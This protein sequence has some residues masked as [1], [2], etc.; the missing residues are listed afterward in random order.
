MR[1][2]AER[3]EP[4]LKEPVTGAIREILLHAV[5]RWHMQGWEEERNVPVEEWERLIPQLSA[6]ERDSAFE[7]D[8]GLMLY[9][10]QRPLSGSEVRW[11]RP[12]WSAYVWAYCRV[13]L[14][15]RL[16]SLPRTAILGCNTDAIYTTFDPTWSDDGTPGQFRSKGHLSGPLASPRNEED[17]RRLKEQAE[18]TA[19]HGALA[20]G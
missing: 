6:E 4:P 5:G 16:L 3:L 19:A 8:N 14:T 10:A 2:D 11:M 17:L 9:I 20:G 12:E 1:A 13:L 7:G 15:R 18:R